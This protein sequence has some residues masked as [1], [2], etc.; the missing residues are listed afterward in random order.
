[1][2]AKPGC[3]PHRPVLAVSRD[4]NQDRA[5]IELLQL[6]IAE[7]PFL[8]RA[9]AEILDDDV[10]F[11]RKPAQQVAAAVAGEVERHAFLVA[12]FRKPHQRVAAFGVGAETTQRVAG[13]RRLDLDH[14]GAE[15]AEN[16]G[17]VRPRDEGSEIEDAD[18]LERRHGRSFRLAARSS[19]LLATLMCMT[20]IIS[21]FLSLTRR[22]LRH[23]AQRRRVP[24]LPSHM[25]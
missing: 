14:L 21:P 7:A 22:G 23:A 15:L 1:M 10:A 13:L 19:S 16:G 5:A 24:R 4:A 12:R 20:S 2:R 17:A 9:G 25:G 11:G 6:I 18:S 3:S 8:Q